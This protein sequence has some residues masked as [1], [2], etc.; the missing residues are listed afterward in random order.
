MA[1]PVIGFQRSLKIVPYFASCA[2]MVLQ[3]LA[4]EAARNPFRP[5]LLHESALVKTGHR[6]KMRIMSEVVI[7]IFL[8][9]IHQDSAGIW[10]GRKK[11][12]QKHTSRYTMHTTLSL[13]LSVS[14]LEA[15]RPLKALPIKI[16]KKST[17]RGSDKK[18]SGQGWEPLVQLLVPLSCGVPQSTP[19]SPTGACRI[20]EL[21]DAIDLESS[22]NALGDN[23][24]PVC[25]VW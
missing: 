2:T 19:F 6:P 16:L 5:G 7:S 12:K 23:G 21:A 18:M 24:V 22:H 15:G 10:R 1:H 3:A 20:E 9:S 8:W 13:T 14:F 4:L 11:K 17:S 25:R